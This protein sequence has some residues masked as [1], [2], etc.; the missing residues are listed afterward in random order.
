VAKLPWARQN[1][2]SFVTLM[3]DRS[4]F[5]SRREKAP[6]KNTLHRI[7][8]RWTAAALHGQRRIWQGELIVV[9]W[10]S[11]LYLNF[12]LAVLGHAEWLEN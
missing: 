5:N 12:I 3:M 2:R 11:K 4:W 6:T 8:Q 7:R 9:R 1:W 10:T